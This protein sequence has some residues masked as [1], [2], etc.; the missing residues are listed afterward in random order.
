MSLT[1]SQPSPDLLQPGLEDGDWIVYLIKAEID[2][3]RLFVALNPPLFF[4]GISLAV[5]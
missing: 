1:T 4:V 2:A 3:N 5:H